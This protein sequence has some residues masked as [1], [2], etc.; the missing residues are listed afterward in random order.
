MVLSR[1]ADGRCSG[2]GLRPLRKGPESGGR[3]NGF[4]S[5]GCGRIGLSGSA[6]RRAAGVFVHG[7]LRHAGG[8]RLGPVWVADFC[9]RLGIRRKDCGF[10]SARV[11]A[12]RAGRE[13]VHD[14]VEM[15]VGT[16]VFC[17]AIAIFAQGQGESCPE[18]EPIWK[19]MDE[20]P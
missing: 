3:N 17:S 5:T 12:Y 11:R 18:R 16:T 2:V 7:L 19:M 14:Y 15:R 9:G 13:T 6:V 20:T 10:G 8:R 1:H 4:G